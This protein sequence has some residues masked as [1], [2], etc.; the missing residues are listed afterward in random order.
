VPVLMAQ[1]EGQPQAIADS[2]QILYCRS[3]LDF[4]PRHCGSQTR[5]KQAE[6]WMLVEDLLNDSI[7]MPTGFVC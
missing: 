4:L 5:G 7:A 3:S 1:I 2:T 6:P